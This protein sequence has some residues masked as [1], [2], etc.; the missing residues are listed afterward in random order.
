MVSNSFGIHPPSCLSL[1]CRGL[2][3]L[4][5]LAQGNWGILLHL[6]GDLAAK[7]AKIRSIEQFT[8]FEV[9]RNGTCHCFWGCMTHHLCRLIH[10]KIS[11]FS[12][13]TARSIACRTTVPVRAE[14][15]CFRQGSHIPNLKENHFFYCQQ[16]K[17]H[18]GPINCEMHTCSIDFFI[19]SPISTTSFPTQPP[20]LLR[21]L[22]F[23][24][25]CNPKNHQRPGS[26]GVFG[27]LGERPRRHVWQTLLTITD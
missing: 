4:K 7:D 17:K 18:S 19:L 9:P 1:H 11:G 8:V 5:W 13:K 2:K 16:E 25:R 23:L 26:N 3:Y 21:F 24:Q 27:C 20:F 22:V 6:T 10:W 12:A 15:W 14:V